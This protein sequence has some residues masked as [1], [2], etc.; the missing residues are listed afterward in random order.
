MYI[1]TESTL[2]GCSLRTLFWCRLNSLP[3][4]LCR[5]SIILNCL[6][7]TNHSKS[8]RKHSPVGKNMVCEKNCRVQHRA[9]KNVL[10][11]IWKKNWNCLTETAYQ[12][13]NHMKWISV[14]SHL[15]P[16]HWLFNGNQ[17]IFVL[18]LFPSYTHTHCILA[19][20]F[21]SSSLLLQMRITSS[22]Y[23]P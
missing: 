10:T 13:P 12:M 9:D 17:H 1:E 2:C 7:T 6:T 4:R 22:L 21:D 16:L 3:G 20:L 14:A 8:F 15:H 23:D 11:K 19:Y 18:M 5:C